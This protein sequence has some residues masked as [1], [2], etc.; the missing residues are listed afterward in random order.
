LI[1]I[2]YIAL[3]VEFCDDDV[4]SPEG[5]RGTPILLGSSRSRSRRKLSPFSW[6]LV[7]VEVHN[8]LKYIKKIYII[9]NI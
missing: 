9:Y 3:S 5:L 2:I 1:L 4:T 7:E 8:N 6:W